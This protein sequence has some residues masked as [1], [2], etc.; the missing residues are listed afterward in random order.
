MLIEYIKENKLYKT[1]MS[2][3]D[4]EIIINDYNNNYKCDVIVKNDITLNKAII[5]LNNFINS[6]DL[7]FLNGYQSWTDTHLTNMEMVEKNILK[8]PK[9]I[10]EKFGMLD[11][12]DAKFYEYNKNKLH[13]YDLFYIKG[14]KNDFFYNLNYKQA[15]LIFEIIKNT[16]VLNLISDV[17]DKTLKTGETFTIFNYKYFDN[18]SSGLANFKKDF[19]SQSNKKILGYS[20]W[21]NY[22]QNI[23]E[24]IILKD[25]EAL[26]NR[27]DLFQIDDG[28]ETFVGD[29]LDIDSKK[30]K[31]GLEEIV[32]KI[33]KK[34]MLAGIWLAPFVCE[35]NSRLFKEHNDWIKK[36]PD[37]SLVKGGGNWSS[38]YALDL[39]KNEVREYITNCLNRYMDLGFDYFKLDFIYAASIV[40][41]K[42]KTKAET[43][44]ES[45]EFLRSILKNKLILG[46][47]NSLFSSSNI[48]DYSRVG[49]DTSLIFDDIWYM[50]HFHRERN[51]TKHT[52]VDTITRSI[53][54]NALFLND[55]D[56][57][58]LRDE[59]N[60]LSK[61]QKNA[62]ITINAIFG[63]ILMTSDNIKT[64]DKEKNEILD[65][66][67][68]I[69]YNAT[70]KY[71]DVKNNIYTIHY[72]LLNKEYI[73]KYDSKK[74][75]LL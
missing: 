18:Y 10:T 9:F 23:N 56:S 8:M 41:N 27:F 29:W 50:K 62:L 15:Y 13:G 47:G 68:N 37:G 64:Y 24:E 57:F 4:L 7:Y 44:R 60:K 16:K 28:Y 2:N 19:V 14:N 35:T 22:Y 21:Y 55:P 3:E 31:N 48:F 54:D 12:G 74:G 49:C 46:C 45:Y 66:A 11:Y 34:G 52:I 1:S 71:F 67:L 33:H 26:D 43:Q 30:F 75:I 32:N 51:S 59:N 42:N 5:S 38:F 39:E 73:I 65:N 58:I 63:S 70:N 69:F 61:A 6:N 25:L 40:N 36:Y 17:K 72:T 20:S 53:F